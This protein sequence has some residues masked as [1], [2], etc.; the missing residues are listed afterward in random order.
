MPRSISKN[1]LIELNMNALGEVY[2]LD[3]QYFKEMIGHL[4]WKKFSERIHQQLT[5][6]INLTNE[7]K[8]LMEVN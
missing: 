8:V 1:N 7:Q 2:A 3:Q 6:N 4:N 5:S